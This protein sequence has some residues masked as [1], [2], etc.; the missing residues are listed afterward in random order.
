MHVTFGTE[1]NYNHRYILGVEYFRE[2]SITGM[3]T[4]RNFEI[5]LYR[6]KAGRIYTCRSQWPRGLRHKLSSLARTL[7]SWVRIPLKTW[8]SVCV[9]SVFGFEALRRADPPSKESCRLSI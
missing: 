2:S 4:V 7:A 6:F 3:G 9:Y 5:T 1:I 8:M